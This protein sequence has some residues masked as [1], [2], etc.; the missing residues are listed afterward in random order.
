MI[1]MA[2]GGVNIPGG[3]ITATSIGQDTLFNT[4]E[5]TGG[6]GPVNVSFEILLNS[7]QYLF[8]D[9]SRQSAQ[10]HVGFDLTVDGHVVLFSNSLRQIGPNASWNSNFS[11]E[12]SHTIT[13]NENEQYRIHVFADRINSAANVPEPPDNRIDPARDRN[14]F[15]PPFQG[16]QRS[17]ADTYFPETSC[18][19]IKLGEPS[20]LRLSRADS[21]YPSERT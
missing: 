1:L 3:G 6:G 11:G 10:S 9:L 5:I 2:S 8:T 17:L 4:F 7:M 14:G 13:L 18:R 15:H 12:L 20:L 21:V 16:G 19:S